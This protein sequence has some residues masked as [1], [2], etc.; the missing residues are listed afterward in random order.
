MLF[1]FALILSKRLKKCEGRFRKSNYSICIRRSK[2]T[3]GKDKDEE[4]K[5]LLASYSHLRSVRSYWITGESISIVHDSL[6]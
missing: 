2:V 1:G 6:S 4:K 3:I 5:N